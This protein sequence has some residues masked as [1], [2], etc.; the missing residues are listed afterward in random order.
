[1]RSPRCTRGSRQ[2]RVSRDTLRSPTVA[3]RRA[4]TTSRTRCGPRR[5]AGYRSCRRSRSV[6]RSARVG[7][8]QVFLLSPA[9][10]DGKRAKMLLNPLATFALAQRLRESGAPLGEVF[11]FLSGLYFRGKLAYA[12][13]FGRLPGGVSSLVITTDR[14]L[15]D[16]DT[17]VTG[18]DLAAFSCVDIAAG[19]ARYTAP[20]ARDA[21]VLA[22]RIGTRARVVLLGSIATG[23]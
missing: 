12:R 4:R 3:W 18:H 20:L 17:V 16:P 19:D 11:S 15:V 14:G 6:P 22:A 21:E 2:A 7:M 13:E 1:M 23:K 8:N 10:C 9:R 5:R